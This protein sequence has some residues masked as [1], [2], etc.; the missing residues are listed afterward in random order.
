MPRDRR[1]PPP[2]HLSRVPPAASA[3]RRA[4]ATAD[5][6]LTADAPGVARCSE[7]DCGVAAEYAGPCELYYDEHVL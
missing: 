6:S 4:I 2:D 5:R 1:N 3:V 7:C